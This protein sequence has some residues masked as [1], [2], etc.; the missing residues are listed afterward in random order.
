[1]VSREVWSRVIMISNRPRFDIWWRNRGHCLLVQ[2]RLRNQPRWHIFKF[3]EQK[4]PFWKQYTGRWCAHLVVLFLTS[5]RANRPQRLPV[6]FW[7]LPQ[8]TAVQGVRW[9]SW[10]V[11][12]QKL[13]CPGYGPIY[14]HGHCHV[15]G[16]CTEA[17]AHIKIH[18]TW[19]KSQAVG[20]DPKNI[21]KLSPDSL[22]GKVLGGKYWWKSSSGKF[23]RKCHIWY[24]WTTYVSK[25]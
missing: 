2:R 14:L 21:W 19:T 3:V 20:S 1:M 24:P 5:W 10:T 17:E 18:R 15:H 4:F 16:Y 22:I 6:H 25:I 9:Y 11:N 7:A 12:T 23:W 8:R 13:V